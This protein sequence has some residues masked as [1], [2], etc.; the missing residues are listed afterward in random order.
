MPDVDPLTKRNVSS[1]SGDLARQSVHGFLWTTLAWGSNRLVILGL[2]LLLARLLTPEDFGVVTAA[3]TIIAM[4]DAAL[5]LGVGAAVVAGQE[6]GVSRKTRTAMTLNIAISVIVCAAGVAA[7]PWIAE[8]FGARSQAGVFALIF[9]YPLFRGAAQVNDAVLKRD[10]L[11][12]RRTLVDLTRAAVR[13]SISIPLAL[14]V[15]GAVSIAAGIVAGEFVAM[16]LL[17]VLVPISPLLR[18]KRTVMSELLHFGGQVTLIRILGSI[19]ASVDYL[20]VGSLISTAALGFYGMAYKLPELLIENVLWIFTAV[21]LAA[22]SRAHAISHDL[23]IASMLRAT[24]ILSIYGLAVGTALAVVAQDVVPVLF[25][26]QWTPAIV[27]MMLISLSLGIMS[28]PWASG[29]VFSA[30]GQPGILVRLDLPATVVMIGALLYASRYGLV[31]VAG[32]LLVFN[33]VY[34]VARLMLVRRVTCVSSRSLFDA[35]AP[36]MAIAAATAATGFLVRSLLPSGQVLSLV[37]LSLVCVA[38]VI[39]ASFVFARTA[40][41]ELVALVRSPRQGN[42][43]VAEPSAS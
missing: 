23:L 29:D 18:I 38:T 21:A 32:A 17:W 43:L 34:C 5:D 27:P 19:R 15:G 31:G 42:P 25:S 2:T 39:G 30:K 3:V 41:V 8:L 13:V 20:I 24:R 22:Y 10:L 26:Q 36:G 4:L 33:V 37:I 14:T 28:I 6:K 35:I 12:R 9:M 7:S 11:F 1:T 16:V 40:I